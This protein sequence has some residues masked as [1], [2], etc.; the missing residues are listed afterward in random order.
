MKEERN[1]PIPQIMVIM[2]VVI[3]EVYLL[4]IYVIQNNEIPKGENNM[5]TASMIALIVAVI[6][7]AS[8]IW[9]QVAQF[10]KDS[11]K[12]GEV[13]EDTSAIEPKVYNIDENVKKVRDEVV[14]KIVPNLGQLDGI[15][16]L[17]DAYK[18]EQAIKERQSPNLN[19]RDILKGTIDLVYDENSK[20]MDDHKRALQKIQQLEVEKLSLQ[21][22][23]HI[24]QEK[25]KS[26]P[27]KQERDH[28]IER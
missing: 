24:C 15:T 9:M 4:Y 25:I 8:G 2:G 5:E 22:E 27:K 26:M 28:S 18:V 3:A 14:E 1:L 19:D 23:L 10:K 21:K 6:G 20:L 17:V 12:I 13:K 7:A 11:G 16:V